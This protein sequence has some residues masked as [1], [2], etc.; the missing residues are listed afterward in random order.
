MLRL[1]MQSA[2]AIKFSSGISLVKGK[3]YLQTE[4]KSR[5][6]RKGSN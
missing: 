3:Q 6:R 2:T 4:N 5:V 1:L